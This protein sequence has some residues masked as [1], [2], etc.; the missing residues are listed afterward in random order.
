MRHAIANAMSRD[1][2]LSGI[3]VNIF[4]FDPV[5]G[6]GN[7]GLQDW[8]TIPENVSHYSAIFME[9]ENRSVMYAA[10]LT[11]QAP[12]F[13]EKQLLHMPGG[14]WYA[15]KA[16]T[17][18][19]EVSRV[20]AHLAADS[21]GKWGT[22]FVPPSLLRSDTQLLEDYALMIEQTKDFFAKGG[23]DIYRWTG[24]NH[25]YF[26]MPNHLLSSAPY[27]V[28]AHHKQVLKRVAPKVYKYFFEHQI[29]DESKS[30]AVYKGEALRELSADPGTRRE[31]TNELDGLRNKAPKTYETLIHF[32]KYVQKPRAKVLQME[33]KKQKKY[34]R[35]EN[36]FASLYQAAA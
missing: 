10:Q 13:T 15:V 16:E 32:S 27:F 8:T 18:F 23:D 19:E 14:H 24:N 20:G 25:A 5:P 21:L 3:L 26:K 17:G 7:L 4:A 28:N 30:F 22:Q 2:R 11:F 1:I 12:H 33:K 34:D 35:Y 6:T 9:N 36:S 29:F 31:L